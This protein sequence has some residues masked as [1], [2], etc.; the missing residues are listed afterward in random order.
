MHAV[1][2]TVIA[3]QGAGNASVSGTRRVPR[4]G[5][6]P[7]RAARTR[8]AALADA[9]ED[10]A[11]L[12]AGDAACRLG[13][14]TRARP[15]SRSSTTSPRSSARRSAGG[16][17]ASAS[18]T[19]SSSTRSPRPTS[20]PRTGLR[21]RHVQPTGHYGCTGK[22]A[23]ADQQRLGRRR[24]PRLRRRRRASR[25][26]ADLAT[27]LGWGE[28]RIDLPA[29]SLRHDPA[30]HRRRGPDDRRLLER[31]RPQRPRR[32]DG[33]LPARRRHPDRRRPR[34]PRGPAV[35]R[36]GLRRAGVRPVRDRRR[37]VR[38]QQRL[39]QRPRPGAHRLDRR[40]PAQP[41]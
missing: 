37:L 17:R 19:A 29:G 20:A 25:W 6:R 10:R 22:N 40:R 23:D 4:A 33:L 36:P 26:R 21:L 38:P 2:V 28:R 18:S 9:A 30:A 15:R 5:G 34:R 12:V 3:F 14:R 41:R 11:E 39:R 24:H 32:P 13:R 8:R 7:R 27:R 1:D 35:L 31:R 16:R